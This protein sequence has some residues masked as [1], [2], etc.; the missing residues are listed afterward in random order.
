MD[1]IVNHFKVRSDCSMCIWKTMCVH[2]IT[3]CAT[4]GDILEKDPKICTGFFGLFRHDG[5]RSLFL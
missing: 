1:V 5:Y 3:D 2:S 4:I